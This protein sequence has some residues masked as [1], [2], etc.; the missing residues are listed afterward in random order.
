MGSTAGDN[1][2]VS[3]TLAQFQTD[4]SGGRFR[5]R[6]SMSEIEWTLSEW[7]NRFRDNNSAQARQAALTSVLRAIARWKAEKRSKKQAGAS[8]LLTKRWNRIEQ[9]EAEIVKVY[10]F[11]SYL[12]TKGAPRVNAPVGPKALSGHYAWEQPA[13]KH[14]PHVS[15]SLVFTQGPA[16][17]GVDAIATPAQYQQAEA[18]LRQNNTELQVY[19]SRAQRL[20]YMLL[21]RNGS[22]MKDPYTPGDIKY[23]PGSANPGGGIYAMDTYG[24]LFAK[25]E[26]AQDQIGNATFWNH[27]SFCRGKSVICAGTIAVERGIIRYID[28]K[29]GHYKPTV[30]NL[31][32]AVRTL[33]AN[34]V[35]VQHLNVVAFEALPGGS[36]AQ[37]ALCEMHATP[38]ECLAAEGRD[39]VFGRYIDHPSGASFLADSHGG[40]F[41]T[42]PYSNGG[43]LGAAG[44]AAPGR[45]WYFAHMA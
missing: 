40:G 26:N 2:V 14:T 9:L 30:A 25:G 15:A 33:V 17:L 13:A 39:G 38:Q 28:N 4:T 3:T 23:Y 42:T 1:P 36:P 44:M 18:A 22:L 27:S 7:E 34:D 35:N 43:Q 8:A 11:Q 29:S 24:N 6:D 31:V 10:R 21:P 16:A 5:G 41:Q 45:K 20:E 37:R 19:L 12:V 32:G